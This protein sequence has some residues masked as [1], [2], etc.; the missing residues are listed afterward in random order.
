M[1]SV[2]ELLD[3]L[4]QIVNEGTYWY[5]SSGNYK[6]YDAIDPAEIHRWIKEQRAKLEAG[7]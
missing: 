2:K 1:T 6:N 3:D 7:Q 4:E 5:E